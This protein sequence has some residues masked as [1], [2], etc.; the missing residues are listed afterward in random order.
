[1]RVFSIAKGFH[2][3]WKH[4]PPELSQKE[5][6]RLRAI[7]LCQ[8]TRDVG[9]VCRT[10][11]ISRATLYRWLNSFDPKDLASL[12]EKSHRPKTLRKPTWSLELMMAV[13]RLRHLYPRWAKDKIAVLL[14]EE[15]FEASASTVGRII[16][17]I[18]KR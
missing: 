1:M 2:Y 9:L 4:T 7:N 15:G 18:K 13:K 5:L 3:L 6:D 10:F 16:G 12:K 11:G 8:E 14:N 17:H